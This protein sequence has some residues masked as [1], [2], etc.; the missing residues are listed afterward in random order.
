MRLRLELNSNWDCWCEFLYMKLWA[1][2]NECMG[3]EGGRM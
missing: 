2:E 3:R 1:R